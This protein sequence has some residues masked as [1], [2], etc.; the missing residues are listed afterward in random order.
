MTDVKSTSRE[1][2]IERNTIQPM[3][4]IAVDINNVPNNTIYYTTVNNEILPQIRNLDQFGAELV[5]HTY[6]NGLGLSHSME[7]LLQ[8]E[9]THLVMVAYSRVSIFLIVSLSLTFVLLHITET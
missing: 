7:I 4:Q 3:S 1:I 9:D 8:L 6:E 5:S 2:V